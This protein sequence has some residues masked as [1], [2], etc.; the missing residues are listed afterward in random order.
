A[1]GV[2][3]EVAVDLIEDTV[4]VGDLLLICSDGLTDMVSDEK[5]SLTLGRLADNLDSAAEELVRLANEAGGKDN[6]SVVLARANASF[7][8]GRRWYERLM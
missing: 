7:A 2:E 6:V 5:I 1:L 8:R 4:E 3:T